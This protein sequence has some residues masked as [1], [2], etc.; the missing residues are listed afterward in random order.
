MWGRASA[1]PD[2][3]GLWARP[4]RTASGRGESPCNNYRTVRVRAWENWSLKAWM[5]GEALTV[6]AFRRATR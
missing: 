3:A 5:C 6:A 1:L 4:T 2:A